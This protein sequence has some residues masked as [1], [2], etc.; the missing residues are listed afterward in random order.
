MMRVAFVIFGVFASTTSFADTCTD[1]NP[2]M[3]E[4]PAPGHDTMDADQSEVE[5]VA[6]LE[7]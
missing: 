3:V 6:G 7:R 1:D 4:G 5:R 2:N